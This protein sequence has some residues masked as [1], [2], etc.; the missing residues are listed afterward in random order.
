MNHNNMCVE[1][2]VFQD[3]QILSGRYVLQKCDIAINSPSGA[4]L[5]FGKA[6]CRAR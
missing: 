5:P 3:E 4:F 6:F 1:P 2:R